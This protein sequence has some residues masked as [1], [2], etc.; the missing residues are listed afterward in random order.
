[1]SN[2]LQVEQYA[3][4]TACEINGGHP[5]FIVKIKNNIAEV[6]YTEPNEGT[7]KIA[8]IDMSRLIRPNEL[9]K[10]FDRGN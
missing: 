2:E 6:H 7:S 5:V 4:D 1:M 8:E 3:V 10:I 9:K